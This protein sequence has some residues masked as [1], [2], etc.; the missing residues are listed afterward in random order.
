MAVHCTLFTALYGGAG[1]DSVRSL[2]GDC[3]TWYNKYIDIIHRCYK[4]TCR[5][6]INV[7]LRHH[8]G[9]L[10]KKGLIKSSSF[11][12]KCKHGTDFPAQ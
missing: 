12:C 11:K 3:R 8:R 4:E 10:D 1:D 6:D 5:G 7:F 9:D 2:C